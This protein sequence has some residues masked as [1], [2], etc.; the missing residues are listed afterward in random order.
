MLVLLTAAMSRPVRPAAASASAMH[1]H[2]SRQPLSV[3]KTWEPGTPG[4]AR[5]R[6]FP[7]SD[8]LLDPGEVEHDRPAAARAEVDGQDVG[9]GGA[10]TRKASRLAR[11]SRASPR[12]KRSISAA[13]M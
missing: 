1:S 9:H 4:H 11:F 13:A 3:S 2:T 8:T 12:A 7:L 10:P 6:P 5:V